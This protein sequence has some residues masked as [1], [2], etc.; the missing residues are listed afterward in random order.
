MVHSKGIHVAD[1]LRISIYSRGGGALQSSC[2]M[3]D[4]MNLDFIQE[5]TLIFMLD[6]KSR[7]GVEEMN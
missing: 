5:G 4:E 7:F 2:G 3:D 1:S 6:D